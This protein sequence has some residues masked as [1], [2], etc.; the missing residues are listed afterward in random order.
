MKTLQHYYYK[1]IIFPMLDSIKTPCSEEV[2]DTIVLY[3]IT[4]TKNEKEAVMSM[5]GLDNSKL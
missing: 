1:V 5:F 4:E 3:L 2:V